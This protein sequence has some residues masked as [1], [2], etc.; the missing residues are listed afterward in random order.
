M[1]QIARIFILIFI[2]ILGIISPVIGQDTIPQPVEIQEE[3]AETPAGIY[4]AIKVKFI[5]GSAI[6]MSIITLCLIV[7]LSFCLERIIYLNLIQI[8]TKKFL[9]E[10]DSDLRA[11]KLEQAK[12]RAKDTR[13]PIASVCYQAL[14]RI[15]EDS[16]A[17][18]RSITAT[19]SVQVGFLEK[20]LSWISLFITIAPSLG[21]LGTVI[22]MIMAFDNIQEQ[23]DINPAIVAGGMKFALITTVA[24]LIVALLLQLFYN[25]ILSK[26]EGIVNEMEDSSIHI[27]DAITRYKRSFNK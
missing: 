17:I 13:G 4:Q 19:G 7:G 16:D 18:D 22:G 20:N 3:L 21:F 27:M 15:E 5:E 10:I 8:N 23:G 1:K 11:C 9:S 24:G 2:L 12:E 14:S 25:Y 6:F 26:V